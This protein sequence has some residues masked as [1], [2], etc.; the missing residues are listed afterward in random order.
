MLRITST[1]WDTPTRGR[2]IAA[3]IRIPRNAAARMTAEV[4]SVQPVEDR[5]DDDGEHAT[6]IPMEPMICPLVGLK[7]ST[8]SS[9]TDGPFC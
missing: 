9:A 7:Y 2:S 3:Q 4:G 5:H 1:S 8:R 6:M